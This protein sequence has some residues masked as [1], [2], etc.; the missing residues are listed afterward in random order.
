MQSERV[1]RDAPAVSV[2]AALQPTS[3]KAVYRSSQLAV[4]LWAAL[5]SARESLRSSRLVAPIGPA[6]VADKLVRAI[7]PRILSRAETGPAPI[8]AD[9]ERP[10]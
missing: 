10:T 9:P 8:W 1:A 6:L 3:C 5:Q 7:D 4:Q 2:Q